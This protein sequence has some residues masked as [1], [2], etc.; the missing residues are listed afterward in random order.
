MTGDICEIIWVHQINYICSF[1]MDI[2]ADILQFSVYVQFSVY[3]T[4]IQ[5]TVKQRELV[6]MHFYL[7]MSKFKV[8]ICT[9]MQANQASLLSG[10]ASALLK[11]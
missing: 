4:Q 8:N 3:A 11:V 7:E 9:S 1:Q 5:S 10:K 2:N 6:V